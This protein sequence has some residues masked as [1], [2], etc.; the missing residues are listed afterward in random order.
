MNESIELIL[1]VIVHVIILFIFLSIF[2]ITYVS[3]I[4]EE[5]FN[6][7]I[8]SLINDNMKNKMGKINTLK[9]YATG[10]LGSDYINAKKLNEYYSGN[11]TPKNI[12]NDWL[13]KYIITTDIYLIILFVLILV[14]IKMV[15]KQDIS[16][17]KGILFK[18]A[19]IFTLVGIIEYL[20]FKYVAMYYVPTKPSD[21]INGIVDDVEK[22]K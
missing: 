2:F 20:F 11:R 9:K 4:T 3:K 5:K 22:L 8:I 14:V 1:N 17:V 19:V 7:E 12:N 13:F 16:P 21:V 6:S 10:I 18:N 15:C